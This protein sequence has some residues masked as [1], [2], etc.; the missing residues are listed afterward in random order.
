[1][2]RKT[3]YEQWIQQVEDRVDT[4]KDIAFV[5]HRNNNK[6]IVC[7]KEDMSEGCKPFWIMFEK[8]DAPFEN[9]TILEKQFGYGLNKQNVDGE[10]IVMNI[11]AFKDKDIIFTRDDSGQFSAYTMI[12]NK[13]NKIK[14]IHLEIKSFVG[15]IPTVEYLE[16]FGEKDSYEK[17]YIK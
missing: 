2:I 11:K 16:I 5:L 4:M 10:C 14:A 6:N 13:T 3:D 7:Y 1:M 8:K 12:Q 17:I 15:I 9:L